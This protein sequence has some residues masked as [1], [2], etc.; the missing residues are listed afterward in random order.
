MKPYAAAVRRDDET[1]VLYAER[2]AHEI[3]V[4]VLAG[5]LDEQVGRAQLGQIIAEA[6]IT[7]V[8]PLA[9]G[10][11]LS[12]EMADE[13][14]AEAVFTLHRRILERHFLDLE[15]IASGSSI[16]GW[17]RNT[18]RAMQTGIAQNKLRSQDHRY[19]RSM[20]TSEM[21]EPTAES[22]MFFASPTDVAAEATA[23]EAIMPALGQ[24]RPDPGASGDPR[25]VAAHISRRFDLGPVCIPA[26]DLQRHAILRQCELDPG[27]AHRSVTATLA[28]R[29]GATRTTAVDETL[30]A[31]WDDMSADALGRLA[32]ELPRTADS[33]VRGM[34][35]ETSTDLE[36]EDGQAPT[37]PEPEATEP[38]PYERGAWSRVPRSS[39]PLSFALHVRRRLGLADICVPAEREVR[40]EIVRRCEQD[41]TLAQRSALDAL[42]ARE[43]VRRVH[44]EEMFVALWDDYPF[45]DLEMI[46]SQPPLL[47][48][49]LVRG[50]VGI[51]PRLSLTV[52]RRVRLA[53]QRLGPENDT[54][55]K[56]A[57]AV[58][59]SYM[60][61]SHQSV[62]DATRTTNPAARQAAIEAH[63]RDAAAWEDRVRVVVDFEGQPLGGT[64]EEVHHT[65]GVLV[66]QAQD[67][68]S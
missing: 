6:R 44:V 64:L 9:F 7:W 47:A 59:A 30:L 53:A 8:T 10:R 50:Y 14:R 33:L 39:R 55:R 35:A 4:R 38:H 52:Q 67:A 3:A 68:R 36:P 31:L 32:A 18:G 37:G 45:G 22:E 48:D 51:A 16:I 29:S 42:A 61:T 65:L 57:A 24:P 54:W 63:R 41:Q 28:L 49:G 46:T 15:Q 56:A 5:E 1:D 34:L 2:A 27:L 25:A 40:E 21:S 62:S 13:T 19:L 20:S 60:A 58:V 11:T 23:I 26:D 43:G 66:R 12:R 17:A